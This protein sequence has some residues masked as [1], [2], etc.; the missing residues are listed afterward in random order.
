MILRLFLY[1]GLDWSLRCVE[2]EMLIHVC[3]LKVRTDLIA[4]SLVLLI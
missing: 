3:L 4:S 2:G 1:V